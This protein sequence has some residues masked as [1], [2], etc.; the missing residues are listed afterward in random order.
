MIRTSSGLVTCRAL[1]HTSV[2]ARASAADGSD[3]RRLS[4]LSVPNAASSSA[5]HSA[6]SC[7]LPRRISNPVQLCEN[8]LQHSEAALEVG[9]LHYER[10]KQSQCMIACSDYQQP[11]SPSALHDIGSKIDDIDPPHVTHSAN[12][13]HFGTASRKI[14]ELCREPFAILTN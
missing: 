13:A 5:C 11:F 1:S 4:V 9:S 12:C 2:R 3:S 6:L 8:A 7:G 10:R 14:V